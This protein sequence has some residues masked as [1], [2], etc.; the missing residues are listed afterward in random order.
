MGPGD[1]PPTPPSSGGSRG[2]R[3]RGARSGASRDRTGDLLLAKQALS[4]LSY[5]PSGSEC[6]ATGA[7]EKA[8]ERRSGWLEKTLL[9]EVEVSWRSL[10]EPEALLLGRLAQEVGGLL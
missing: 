8:L 10:L 7:T 5:G 9:V 6:R 4:Q 3:G 2:L 1:V